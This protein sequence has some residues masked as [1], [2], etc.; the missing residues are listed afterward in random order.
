MN[1]GINISPLSPHIQINFGNI[2][3]RNNKEKKINKNNNNE[4]KIKRKKT[5]FLIQYSNRKNVNEK[6]SKLSIE[7]YNSIIE[8]TLSQ[9]HFLTIKY[10]FEYNNKK[11][12]TNNMVSFEQRL[13]KFNNFDYFIF[14]MENDD[15]NEELKQFSDNRT[16]T[17]SGSKINSLSQS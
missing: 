10:F 4:E 1:S 7:N 14:T 16:Y 5:F 6:K 11:F 12:I 9:Y 8:S 3:N 2:Q 17:I 13:A 15:I